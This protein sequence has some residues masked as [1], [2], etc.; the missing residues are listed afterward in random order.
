[1]PKWGG[2]LFS[3]LF[4]A[5]LGLCVVT[6]V[7]DPIYSATCHCSSFLQPYPQ[8][9]HRETHYKRVCVGGE[10][11]NQAWD[12]TT[13]WKSIPTNKMLP[14]LSSWLLNWAGSLPTIQSILHACHRMWWF[15]IPFWPQQLH[16]YCNIYAFSERDGSNTF[17]ASC[18]PG[19]KKGWTGIKI[20]AGLIVSYRPHRISIHTFTTRCH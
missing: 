11:E 13:A 16:Y 2:C 12:C 1:M 8:T 3:G 15:A 20:Q 4:W 9:D 17:L 10:D 18:H 7:C 19:N 14:A 6:D 5:V